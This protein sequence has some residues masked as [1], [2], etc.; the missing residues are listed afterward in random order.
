MGKL[1]AGGHLNG[2]IFSC[3][4]S[5]LIELV[6]VDVTVFWTML[7]GKYILAHCVWNPIHDA[8]L[9]A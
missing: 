2:G 5:S 9:L 4:N 8:D 1:G 6:T 3:V 7:C